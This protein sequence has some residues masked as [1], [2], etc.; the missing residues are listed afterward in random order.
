MP[1]TGLNTVNW[2]AAVETAKN[3]YLATVRAASWWLSVW[4]SVRVVQTGVPGVAPLPLRY[5]VQ[6]DSS[7]K[8]Y[9]WGG[10]VS[11]E[12]IERALAGM[13]RRIT[14]F[15]RVLDFGCGCGRT[16]LWFRD[17]GQLTRFH[18]S[19]IDRE[20]VDWCRRNL[21]FATYGCNQPAPPLAY[22]DGHFDLLYALSVFTHLDAEQ[23]LAWMDELRRVLRPGGVALLTFLG[24]D[25]AA[26]PAGKEG[27]WAR[28]NAASLD[29][30]ERGGVLFLPRR[31]VQGLFPEGYGDTFNTRA[32]LREQLQ[33][34]F[35]LVEYQPRGLSGVLDLVVLQ[36][37]SSPDAGPATTAPGPS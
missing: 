14:D 10:S 12:A 28:V 23:Q 25:P 19:D 15:Q 13:G 3:S 24:H 5:R 33:A 16:L 20:A 1:H 34:H 27:P 32:Y 35:D 2:A 29:E 11:R 4:D 6:G 22:P 18:G 31:R 9:L 26:D 37:P 8:T 21:P 7:L 17:V 30:L 36:K